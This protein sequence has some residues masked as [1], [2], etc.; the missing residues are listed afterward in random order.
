MSI[1]VLGFR[2]QSEGRTGVAALKAM[3][4]K[5]PLLVHGLCAY[6]SVTWLLVVLIAAHTIQSRQQHGT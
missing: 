1:S 2:A 4:R 5:H 3:R 6:L